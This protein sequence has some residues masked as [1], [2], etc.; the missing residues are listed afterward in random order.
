MFGPGR[1]VY[2]PTGLR[3]ISRVMTSTLL[4]HV[5]A[6][7]LFRHGLVVD[8]AL[9][10]AGDFEAAAGDRG[11][12]LGVALQGHADGVDRGRSARIR[13]HAQDFPRAYAAAVLEDRFDVEVARAGQGLGTE[14]G[15]HRFRVRIAVQD[16]GLAAFLVVQ[17]QR[18][19]DARLVRPVGMRRAAGV[20]DEIARVRLVRLHGASRQACAPCSASQSM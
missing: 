5:R 15:Q 16:A 14:I 4:A 6:L 7:D 18:H 8:P 1:P 19:R 9:S 12:D 10:V 2:Q 13:E 20:A 17:H 11:G 3:P